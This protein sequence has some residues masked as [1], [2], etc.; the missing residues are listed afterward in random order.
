MLFG[1]CEAAGLLGSGQS[2]AQN[3]YITNFFVRDGAR[4]RG[5]GSRLLDQATAWCESRG[6]YA[7]ILWPTDRGKVIGSL[8]E[9]LV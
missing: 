4:G 3:A 6:T 8:P 7:V 2:L 1:L 9:G 5:I